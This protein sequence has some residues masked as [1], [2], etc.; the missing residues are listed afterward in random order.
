[1]GYDIIGFPI[2]ETV[3]QVKTM[4]STC[5]LLSGERVENMIVVIEIMRL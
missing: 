3:K 4:F 2:V 1:V 5:G